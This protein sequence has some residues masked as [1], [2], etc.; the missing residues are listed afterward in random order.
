MVR[1]VACLQDDHRCPLPPSADGRATADELSW[2]EHSLR[3]EAL[4][5]LSVADCIKQE[6]WSDS[7]AAQLRQAAHDL[8]AMVRER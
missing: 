8:L 6:G 7:V 4:N 3:Q 1:N 5:L 2:S